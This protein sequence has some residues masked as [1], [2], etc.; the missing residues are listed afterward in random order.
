MRR[1]SIGLWAALAGAI[2]Q[3][4]ALGSNFYVIHGKKG[5]VTRDAWLGIPHASDLLLAS[6][7]VTVIAV[8]VAWQ[9]R[10][11]VRGRNLGLI[12]AFFG[13]LATAQIVY[14]MII[15]PF[16]CLHYE[17][18]ASQTAHVTLLVGIYVGA[19]G[20]FL[21]LIGGLLAAVTPASRRVE[22][23]PGVAEL[24]SGITPWLGLG[25]IGMV[26]AFIAP[27][28]AFRIY[29]VGSFFGSGSVTYWGGWI[30]LP[31]T[32]SL[33]L[34]CMV[35]TLLLVLAAVRGRAPLTPSGVGAVVG[36]LAF[37][38]GARILYRIGQPPFSTAGGASDVHTGTVTILPAFWV[39]FAGA[40]VACLAGIVHA[41]A[42]Y[43]EES[44]VEERSP[45]ARR[46]EVPTGAG[47][48][49]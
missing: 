25:A 30:P 15:P 9:A 24:Q 29:K 35:I 45:R 21:A 39:G 27:F 4:V 20:A 6:A 7:V 44:T 23:R 18:S 12:V 13:L 17:C 10:S 11:P 49:A 5:N 28:T 47:A 1:V 26:V 3:F 22:A 37:V 14:R 41:Y 19:V 16:G 34:A 33:V 2:L 31:H 8:I 38:A 32:S 36:V 48:H 40:A 42:H 43:R 46:A